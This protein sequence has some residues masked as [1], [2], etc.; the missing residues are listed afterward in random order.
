MPFFQ[1]LG[2]NAILNIKHQ[3]TYLPK[4]SKTLAQIPFS[5]MFQDLSLNAIFPNFPRPWPR[6]HFPKLCKTL[7]QLQFPNYQR[8]H[9]PKLSKTLAQ[10]PFPE[11]FQDFG[12]NAIFRSFP[13]WKRAL[14]FSIF[15]LKTE[16][17][18]FRLKI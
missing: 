6:C 11:T 16:Q 3:V 1:N 12:P 4:R 14:Q 17:A 8:C 9:F 7:A 5:Q 2:P 18:R 10:M 15:F 13:A